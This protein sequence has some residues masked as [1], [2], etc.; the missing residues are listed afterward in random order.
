MKR[1]CYHGRWGVSGVA[2]SI[3][4]SRRS[5][6]VSGCRTTKNLG[7]AY[8]CLKSC[9]P[10]E[11]VGLEKL[12]SRWDYSDAP[13]QELEQTALNSEL[14]PDQSLITPQNSKLSA[15][16]GQLPT[17]PRPCRE[18][19]LTA[20]IQI[21]RENKSNRKFGLG[22]NE[23]YMPHADMR[24]LLEALHNITLILMASDWQSCPGQPRDGSNILIEDLENTPSALAAQRTGTTGFTQDTLS[25]CVKSL[26]DEPPQTFGSN[27]SSR[28]TQ[29]DWAQKIQAAVLQSTSHFT[30]IVKTGPE[31]YRHIDSMRL[32]SILFMTSD[33]LHRFVST[34]ME[35][36]NV[37]IHV[38]PH[39]FPIGD[40]PAA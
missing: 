33:D 29:I 13:W 3:Q 32:D 25:E 21:H 30:A 31:Q 27:M 10:A 16:P 11:D 2:K 8:N 35:M 34:R 23:V 20:N 14:H 19:Q 22:M 9:T 26:C 4:T 1:H 36:P 24:C 15:H 38:L 28:N 5:G 12:T 17:W 7:G 40:H 6:E 18:T 39:N 37:M